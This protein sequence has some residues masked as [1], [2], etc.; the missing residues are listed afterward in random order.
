ML[1]RK[2]LQINFLDDH[3]PCENCIYFT[4]IDDEDFCYER[5][6]TGFKPIPEDQETKQT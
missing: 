5:C 1:I 3:N 2:D 4:K 6:H